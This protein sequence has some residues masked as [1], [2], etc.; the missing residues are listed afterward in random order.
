MTLNGAPIEV[1]RND[2][3]GLLDGGSL[4]AAFEV[5]DVIAPQTSAMLDGLAASLIART[6]D[7]PEDGTL[8]PGDAGLFT[9]AGGV[10][11]PAN[12]TGVALR[13]S[14][15]ASVDPTAGGDAS[16]LRD[17]LNAVGPGAI[18]DAS[19]LRGLALALAANDPA[20]ASSGLTGNRSATG[21]AAELSAGLF[22]SADRA[23][24]AALFEQASAD[25]LRDAEL[26]A[27]GVDTDQELA[28]LLQVEQAYAANARVVSVVD[29]LMQ[30]LLQI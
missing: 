2:S 17:G 8:A 26:A 3:D 7:L 13:I 5:R 15:N 25:A 19:I 4:E 12:E 18:G 20:S 21:F 23:D 16:R 1:G 28:R 6:Q 22:V 10:F 29:D 9:D 11:D 27:T 14:L 30:R 24:S